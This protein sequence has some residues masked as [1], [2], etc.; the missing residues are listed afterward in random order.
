L[1]NRRVEWRRV[2]H[3]HQLTLL[4][5][6]VESAYRAMMFPDTWLPTCTVTTAFKLPVVLTVVSISRDQFG[7]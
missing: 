7:L 5:L 1:R 2:D 4:Y 6:R 3:R